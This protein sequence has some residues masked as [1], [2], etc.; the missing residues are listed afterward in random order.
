[1]PMSEEPK[2]FTRLNLSF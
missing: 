1:M 2:A